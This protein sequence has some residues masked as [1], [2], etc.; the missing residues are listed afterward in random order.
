M[1][2]KIAVIGA[3][4]GGLALAA[5]LGSLGYEVD[6]YE[7]LNKCGG[8]ANLIEDRGFKFDTGPSF[9]L[10]PDFFEEIFSFCRRDL[11]DY[12]D[13]VTLDI[14][15]KIFYPNN[16]TLTIYKDKEKT[17]KELE[18]I[19][20]GSA[21]GYNKFLKDTGLIYQTVKPL[22]YRSFSKAD[23]F[24]PSSLKLI[25]KLGIRKTY[26]QLAK[27]Y[28]K[29]QEL[30]YA[31]TFEAMFI[32]VSPFSTPSFYSVITYSDHSEK[33]HHPLGGMYQIPLAL[34]KMAKEFKVNF[35]YNFEIDKFEKKRIFRLFSGKKSVE[36]DRVVINAD[37]PYANKTIL[38]RKI[39]RLKYSCSV[40][41]IYLGLKEKIEALEHHNLF[42]AHD[43]PRNL[44][45]IFSDSSVP[46]DPSFYVHVPT[47][48]DK[49]LAPEGKDIA[50]I[51]VPVPN[52]KKQYNFRKHEQSLR[53]IVFKSINTKT[54]IDLESLIEIE[55]RFYPDDF[56]SRY[57]IL[58]AATFGLS[59]N[60]FQSA[61][62]R[63]ANFDSKYKGLYYVGASTQPGGGL[64]TVLAS[65]KIAANLI[66][67]V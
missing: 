16:K 15:Y 7:K 2:K 19:E 24:K 6:V 65:S 46:D 45:A 41:L 61:F 12:L 10:M 39:P 59:H 67:S 34:E 62:F 29:S 33:I 22:L 57:N 60:L 55:H 20:A 28:F 1:K 9:V 50:Y 58:N 18:R 32:G 25:R 27:Q 43:L 47:R 23:I 44:A 53:K 49:S 3:G 30:C 11:S 35:N 21:S 51:L 42:F 63:P 66:D 4:V 38:G 40:Y 8:R 26:W 17:E 37:W 31:F 5:R 36:A 13:L 14:N 64:P 52:L 54:G 56:I 48:T